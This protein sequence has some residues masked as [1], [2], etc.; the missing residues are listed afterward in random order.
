MHQA[1]GAE[2][3]LAAASSSSKYPAM[4]SRSGPAERSFLGVQ[5]ATRQG[6]NVSADPSSEARRGAPYWRPLQLE[7]AQSQTCPALQQAVQAQS[8]VPGAQ[9]ETQVVP[10]SCWPQPQVGGGGGG[11]G[12]GLTHLWLWQLWPAGQLPSQTPPQPSAAP[13]A[14]PAQLGVQQSHA[15]PVFWQTSLA[16]G[17]PVQTL[18]QPS[19]TPQPL[20]T[21][22]GTHAH[23]PALQVEPG[24]Q[25]PL[26]QMPP[27]PSSAPQALPAQSGVQQS[28]PV[29]ELRQLAPGPHSLQMPPQPLS[30]PQPLPVHCGTHPHF[31]LLHCWPAGQPPVVHVPPQPSGAPQVVQLGLQGGLGGPKR[32]Q[33]STH[34]P[35]WQMKPSLQV[36][37]A[38]GLATQAPATQV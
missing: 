30:A 24:W 28:Q 14:W 5:S 10:T 15:A 11:G 7:V 34:L 22:S 35:A 13:Q 2:P 8:V 38:Q 26:A 16:P 12:A 9:I 21:Q 27:Q 4:S 6:E 36:T 18:L 19:A 25:V 17:Q 37:P 23:L 31:P 1:T 33:E 32:S 29:P 20:V 3:L